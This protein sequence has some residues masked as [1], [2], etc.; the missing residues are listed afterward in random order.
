MKKN[1]KWL[2]ITMCSLMVTLVAAPLSVFGADKK[3]LTEKVLEITKYKKVNAE[4][5]TTPDPSE[6]K[7]FREWFA[8]GR[9]AYAAAQALDSF[10]TWDVSYEELCTIKS[11]RIL[12]DGE[13]DFGGIENL[14]NLRALDFSGSTNISDLSALE[15]IPGLYGLNVDGCGITS[16]D[17]LKYFPKLGYLSIGNNAIQDLTPLKEVPELEFLYFQNIKVTDFSPIKNLTGLNQLSGDNNNLT[18]LDFMKKLVN[19]EYAT[20]S[21]NKIEDLTPLKELVNLEYLNLEDN[22]VKDVSPLSG[23]LKLKNL[24]LR[25]NQIIDMMPLKSITSLEKLN[26]LGNQITSVGSLGSL[27]NL[28]EL[29]FTDNK[30]TDAS[31]VNDLPDTIQIGLQINRIMNIS[32]VHRFEERTNLDFRYQVLAMPMQYGRK[33][34]IVK[35]WNP[36]IDSGG[37]ATTN[38]VPS[39]WPKVPSYYE[40]AT[41]QVYFTNVTGSEELEFYFYDTTKRFTGRVNFSYLLASEKKVTFDAEDGSGSQE[42]LVYPGEVIVQPKKPMKTGYDFQGWFVADGNASGLWD[43]QQ[44]KMPNKA[45]TLR[46]GWKKSIYTVT[47]EGNGADPTSRL[48]E[49]ASFSIGDSPVLIATGVEIQRKGYDFIAWNTAADGSGISYLQEESYEMLESMTLYAIW[50]KDIPSIITPPV[51]PIVPIKPIA[52]IKPIVPV[53]P[54]RPISPTIGKVTK[55][56]KQ[57]DT[58]IRKSKSST[59]KASK[60]KVVTL[61]LTGDSIDPLI[62]YWGI[63]SVLGATIY[64]VRRKKN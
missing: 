38:I 50:K 62:W 57:L 30:I 63:F 56:P 37:K 23:M 21:Y 64:L 59:N 18:T 14:P 10:T 13:I 44:D 58:R 43:F 27:T 15:I 7:S 29:V 24:V 49:V 12:A 51:K 11:L 36:S 54:V 9:I 22:L 1:H 5:V 52:P 28:K 41:N 3:A 55:G 32:N 2:K 40:M 17:F 39:S 34:G 61:P 47:Y 60:S 53:R 42:Q 45:L 26:L 8:D 4:I 48:P 16:L 20:L 33:D 6:T 31:F 25:E 19:L 46:A 35:V